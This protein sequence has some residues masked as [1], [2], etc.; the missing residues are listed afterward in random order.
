MTMRE[1]T[2]IA[3][4]ELGRT[5]EEIQHE[6]AATDQLTNERCGPVQVEESHME[7]GLD[8]AGQRKLINEIKSMIQ[9]IAEMPKESKL[10][11]GN[12]IMKRLHKDRQNN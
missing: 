1:A 8:H 6:L 12:S 9:L 4:R 5:E 2:T 11:L 10:A 7:L 3:L